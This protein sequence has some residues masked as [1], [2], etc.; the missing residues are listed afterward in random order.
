MILKTRFVNN[1]HVRE[2]TLPNLAQE[3]KLAL[4]A[5]RK[6]T[7]DQLHCLFEAH[8]ALNRKQDVNV[9]WHDNEIMNLEFSGPNVVSE[10]VDQKFGHAHSLKERPSARGAGCNK[11]GS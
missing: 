3:S 1:T 6:S 7:F 11:E 5:K 8:I 9:V 10:Y 2:S 4:S